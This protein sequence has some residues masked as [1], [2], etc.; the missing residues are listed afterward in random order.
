MNS[1][2]SRVVNKYSWHDMRPNISLVRRLANRATN[3]NFPS[4]VQDSL[5]L[6]SRLWSDGHG[7]SCEKLDI[8]D[9]EGRLCC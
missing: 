5:D 2:D 3:T 8:Q 4:R 1:L 9:K 7:E 6:E